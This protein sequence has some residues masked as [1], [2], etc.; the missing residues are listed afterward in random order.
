[1]SFFADE[2]DIARMAAGFTLPSRL[3][4]LLADRQAEEQEQIESDPPQ[5]PCN[6]RE[7]YQRGYDRCLRDFG[8][9]A[10]ITQGY[11][12]ILRELGGDE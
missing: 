4:K 6:G 12:D 2:N 5:N 10:K 7:W 8:P 11:A 1:M 9:D 3:A